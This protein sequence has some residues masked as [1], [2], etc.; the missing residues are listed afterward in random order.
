MT[1]TSIKLVEVGPRDGL[2]NEKGFV[3]TEVKLKFIQL[4]LASNLKYIEATSFVSAKAIPQL[5][6]HEQLFIALPS[7]SAHFSALVPNLK[8]LDN[9]LKCHVQNIAVFAAASETFSQKN[10]HHSIA[11]SLFEY[12]KVIKKAK[13]HKLKVR[14]YVSCALGCPYEGKVSLSQVAHVATKLYEAGCDEIALG[15]TIGVGTAKAAKTMVKA[16][17]THLPINNIALHFHD[18]Y[19]QALANI[20]ACLELGITTLDSSVAGLGG[21]PYAKGATGN[22]A[23]EEVLYL[24]NGLGL[25]TGVSLDKLIEAG[26]YICSQLKIA[27]RSKVATA[28]IAQRK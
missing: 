23:T 21:C 16:V 1:K 15:D 22:I 14:G 4:L 8:G 7:H 26:D 13:E 12:A 11:D 9:A 3:S 6:D 27:N 24:L 20:L 25:E 17:S 10:I 5:A 2:Q 19:G 28:M 18:T